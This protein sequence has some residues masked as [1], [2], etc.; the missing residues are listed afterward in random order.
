M[1]LNAS[2]KYNKTH[3]PT[4]KVQ[5]T[6]CKP[7]AKIFVCAE[8]FK[9][10]FVMRASFINCFLALPTEQCVLDEVECIS[11]GEQKYKNLIHFSKLI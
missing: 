4:A 1:T 7:R 3:E 6:Y 11:F 10:G 2:I 8:R 5:I 9:L